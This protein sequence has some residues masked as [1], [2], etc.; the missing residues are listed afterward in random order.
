[1]RHVHRSRPAWRGVAVLAWIAA[2][3][4]T[5]CT[6]VE[7]T[8]SGRNVRSALAGEVQDCVKVGQTRTSVM[9][10][11]VFIDRSHTKVAEELTTL[12]RNEAAG[13]GANTVVASS[14]IERGSQS[15]DIY[16][17]ER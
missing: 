1:M 14:P 17:C 13:I 2:L 9:S 8:P 15:F 11:L 10:R 5:G 6:W 16:R 3:A 4:S 7:I 12:A